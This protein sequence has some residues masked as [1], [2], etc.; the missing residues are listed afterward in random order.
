[1]HVLGVR[2]EAFG[3]EGFKYLRF[4]GKDGGVESGIIGVGIQVEKGSWTVSD[5]VVEDIN[6]SKFRQ[7]PDG[8]VVDVWIVCE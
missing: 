2:G 3:E 8:K 6:L 1:M 5:S 4:V 7:R